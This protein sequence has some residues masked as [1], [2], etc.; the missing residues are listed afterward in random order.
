MGVGA[1]C[2]VGGALDRRAMTSGRVPERR[3]KEMPPDDPKGIVA[4][5]YDMIAERYAAWSGQ[6]VDAPRERYLAL[7]EARLPLGARVL[8]LGCGTG[9]LTTARLAGRFDVTGVDISPRSI[10]LARRGVPGATFVRADMTRMEFPLARFDA[11]AAFYALT[12]V[13]RDE[14]AGLLGKIARWLRPGGLLVASMGAG[15][16]AGEIE[17]DWLGVPMYFSHFDAATNE[18]LVRDTG[19]VVRTAMVET[20]D[21]DGM[22][23]GFLWVVAEVP[24]VGA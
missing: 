8:E 10:M 22:P 1:T 2:R 23:V 5:G 11:V 24:P 18:R 3:E 15:S 20:T 12:H 16:A 21:E 4:R 6:G 14:H 17:P 7:L 9:A 13:P 19:F